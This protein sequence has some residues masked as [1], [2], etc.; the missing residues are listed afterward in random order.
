MTPATRHESAETA[1]GHDILPLS[2]SIETPSKAKA[3]RC[4]QGDG[5]A[6]AIPFSAEVGGLYRLMCVAQSA[7]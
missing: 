3:V 7:T 6:A 1:L 2:I 4:I 5:K